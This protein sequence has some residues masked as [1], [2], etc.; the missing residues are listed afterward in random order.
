MSDTK[1]KAYVKRMGCKF[2]VSADAKPVLY[3]GQVEVTQKVL[4]DNKRV[5]ASAEEWAT[6]NPVKSDPE[7]EPV[8]TSA[9]VE[10]DE[11]A[12]LGLLE[13]A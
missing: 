1:V 7:P 13:E 8:P 9:L 3:G 10:D 5:L 2:K 4:D 12:V 11:D 6:L